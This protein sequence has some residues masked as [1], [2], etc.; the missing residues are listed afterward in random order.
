M[1]D[2]PQ[3]ILPD[4][5]PEEIEG[6]KRCFVLYVKFPKSKWKQIE[7]AEKFDVE[8]NKIYQDLKLEY[9]EKYM[10]KTDPNP[11]SD[12]SKIEDMSDDM[13]KGYTGEMN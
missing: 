4:Y 1:T 9:L 2:K 12:L 6:I 5:S 7:K 13:K 8:G 10:P 11:T 3:V